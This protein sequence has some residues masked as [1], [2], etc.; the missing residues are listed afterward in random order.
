MSSLT[1]SESTGSTSPS[2]ISD[3]LGLPGVAPQASMGHAVIDQQQVTLRR[4]TDRRTGSVE[5]TQRRA[6]EIYEARGSAP[7][8]ALDDWLQ[9]ERELQAESN[10]FESTH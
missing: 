10:R 9:A 4:K 1:A 6:Y 5:N 2:G 3:Q 7:G 8:H